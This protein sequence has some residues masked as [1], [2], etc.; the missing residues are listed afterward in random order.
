MFY[1]R[2]PSP[3]KSEQ[4]RSLLRT[5]S[6]LR[7]GSAESP[8][9]SLVVSAS[10]RCLQICSYC[11]KSGRYP[12]ACLTAL[13]SSS[14]MLASR[15]STPTCFL[16]ENPW[17]Q[18]RTSWWHGHSTEFPGL[19]QQQ[20]RHPTLPPSADSG[21]ET[22]E[23]TVGKLAKPAGGTEGGRTWSSRH[24]AW[25]VGRS[26]RHCSCRTVPLARRFPRASVRHP[27]SCPLD[28]SRQRRPK[29]CLMEQSVA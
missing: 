29:A 24:S 16:K 23:S 4:T 21:L 18:R 1:P 17:R 25:R 20:Q 11:A 26:A 15:R 7:F 5:S 9:A 8:L 28:I 27:R 22:L 6:C 19:R 12:K 10:S 3:C 14:R 2:P 13:S